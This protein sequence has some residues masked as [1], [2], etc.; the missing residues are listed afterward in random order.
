MQ[1]LNFKPEIV[2]GSDKIGEIIDIKSGN[3]SSIVLTSAKIVYKIDHN[4]N[5]DTGFKV[6]QFTKLSNIVKI[7]CS[8][9][10][11][12]ALEREDV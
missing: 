10:H 8:F 12:V 6:E 3:N 2:Q 1:N 11:F 7:S 9:V 4:N 5:Q